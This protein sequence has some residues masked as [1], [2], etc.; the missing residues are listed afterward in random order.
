MPVDE[1]YKFIK[2]IDNDKTGL[3]TPPFISKKLRELV[4]I[5]NPVNPINEKE[6]EK[7]L[8]QTKNEIMKEMKDIMQE[9]LSNGL[10]K[11]P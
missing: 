5:P 6:L 7:K 3:S 2:T 8:E 4:N 11:N 10:V 1:V 9:L